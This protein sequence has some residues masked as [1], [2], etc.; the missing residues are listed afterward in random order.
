MSSLEIVETIN[1]ED[2]AI[3]D[4][5]RKE[6]PSIARAA[7]AVV[8]SLQN[9]GRLIY[10]GAGT[11]GRL[12]VL[13]ASECPPTFNTDPKQ[14]VGLIAGGY[15]AL[16]QSIEGAEDFPEYGKKDLEEIE[17][18]KK[19]TVVG[20]ATSGRTPYV[21][22][23]VEYANSLGCE[24]VGLV[25][26]A[27][28]ELAKVAKVTICPIVGPEIVTGST[29]MKAG[30]AT[31]LVLNS[32]TTAAMIRLGKTFGN[33]MVDLR[34]TNSKL[35]DRSRRIVRD[36]GKVTDDKAAELLG[37]CDGEVKTAIVMAH[38]N[39]DAIASRQLLLTAK[40]HLRLALESEI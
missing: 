15:S 3:A 17:L 11:S 24:T 37:L 9:G 10:I 35:R 27:E 19:D 32:I 1:R 18:V 8:T 22:G 20:I 28:S 31:K 7:D 23:G 34:A 33:L 5:V 14:V 2:Q 40:G 26:N 4:A 12:G 38:R 16:V 25:C 30:T 21:I 29:R 13:D 36:L 6:A 39:V